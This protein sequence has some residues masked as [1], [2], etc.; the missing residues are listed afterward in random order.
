MAQAYV[1]RKTINRIGYLTL[2]RPDK[3]N[4]LNGQ[5]VNEIH[6]SLDH[7]EKE[8]A[9]KV[10]VIR[11]AGD[12]FCS[13]ADLGYLEQLKDFSY[14]ENLEDSHL[15]RSLFE[16]IYRFPKVVIAQ[17]HG[18]A[19]AGGCGLAN[20][21][22]F[23]FATDNSEFGFPEVKIGFLPALVMVFLKEKIGT[24]KARQLLLTGDMINAEEA[25]KMGMVFRVVEKKALEGEVKAFAQ[26]LI[27]EN[28]GE[29]LASIKKM[30]ALLP[31]KSLD[32][33]LRYAAEMNAR[34]RNTD[35]CKKGIA[36]FL[37][38]QKIQW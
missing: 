19:I 15:L 30:L 29:S 34:A 20:V 10:L 25:L 24:A 31:G 16:K 7:F 2:K 26:K 4:A 11:A 3:K 35:D 33:G 22:D 21:C 8:D 28:S 17:V 36:A 5:M 18:A 13:G 14:E 32:E 23:V 38:K 9:V 37:N 12:V 1:S 6:Q 27:H